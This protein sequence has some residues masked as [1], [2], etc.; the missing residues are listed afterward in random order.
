MAGQPFNYRIDVVNPFTAATQ[1]LQLGASIQQLQ[2]QRE[3]RERAIAAAEAER[4]AKLQQAEALR[5]ETSAFLSNPS[6]QGV[7]RLST[8]LP[9]DRADAL[10]KG[11][12]AY[13]ESERK[14]IVG[15]AAGISSALLSESPDVG[16]QQLRT[17]ADAARNSGDEEKAKQYEAYAKTA[18]IDPKSASLM[19]MLPLTGTEEGKKA[20]EAILSARKAP[21][22]IREGEAKA[23]TAEVG[24]KYAE[25][26]AIQDMEKAGWD[27]KKLKQDVEFRP[28]ELNL[29][30]LE[31]QTA[32]ENAGLTRQALQLKVDDARRQYEQAIADRRASA[33]SA[34]IGIVDM[35]QSVSDLRNHSG[36]SSL[37]GASLTPGA[38]FIPGS[39][40]SGAEAVLESLKARAFMV[41]VDKMR[42][43]GALG[44]KEG[45]KIEA[46]IAALRPG[47]PEKDALKALDAIETSMKR[48]DELNQQK[49]GAPPAD[50]FAGGAEP[51][52]DTAEEYN[53]L[54]SGAIYIDKLDGKKYRKP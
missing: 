23:T 4:I 35:R 48:L 17:L 44:E 3:D 33:Q 49:Y 16:V 9:K 46:A 32:R 24:A 26:K 40:T 18:E 20:I 21:A 52:V 29:R 50:S 51:M 5:T 53:A 11:W 39:D 45:A 38:R 30:R 54:P 1:G 7:L 8:M 28:L 13:G 36:F 10:A 14:K 34:Q 6:A 47:M 41:G 22:E 12:D 37:F 31:A 42:G 15:T 2:Q 19:V 27:I 43:L 25:P